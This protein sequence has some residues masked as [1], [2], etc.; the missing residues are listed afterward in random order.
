MVISEKDLFKTGLSVYSAQ[1]VIMETGEIL[2]ER[3]TLVFLNKENRG[4]EETPINLF[5][6]DIFETDYNK[7]NPV[8][9]ETLKFYKENTE[10]HMRLE[11][12]LKEV[13]DREHKDMYEEL[14]KLKK[15]NKRIES[16]E[17]EI[18]RL[19]KQLAQ[20]NQGDI[21]K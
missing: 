4:E 17:K 10:E 9:R 1:R 12:H 21:K 5:I 11:G 2:P 6:D 13:F 3:Q 16:L 8:A 7:T 15:E 14:E 18:K 20:N 19:K